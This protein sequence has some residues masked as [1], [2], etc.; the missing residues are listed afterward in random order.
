MMKKLTA[1]FN[2]PCKVTQSDHKRI[3]AGVQ[4]LEVSNCFRLGH[5][6]I[7]TNNKLALHEGLIK[8]A[9]RQKLWREDKTS[10]V[11]SCDV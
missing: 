1:T 5:W 3:E 7:G 4:E 6:F 11:V 9:Q 2:I 8:S 10:K